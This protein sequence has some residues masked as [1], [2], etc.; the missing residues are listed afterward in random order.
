MQPALK[1]TSQLEHWF[2][3]A[4]QWPDAVL[5]AYNGGSIA[6]L[7]G[8]ILRA[9]DPNGVVAP[10]TVLPPVAPQLLPP[11]F[12]AG[13]RAVV[14]IVVD[15]LGQECLRWASGQ[16]ATHYLN[17]AQHNAQLTS[18][19]PSTTA[20]ALTSLQNGLAPARH[21]MAGYTLYLA[22]QQ[23]VINMITW[24]P[25]AGM[26]VRLPMPVPRTFLDVPNLYTLLDRVKIPSAIVSNLAFMD[27]P[28]TN[29]HSPGVPYYGHRTP[30]EFAGLLLQQV[31]KPGR[32]FVFGYWDGFD[33]LAHTHG[34]R[35]IICLDEIRIVDLALGRGLLER[36]AGRA[37]DIVV[38]L[39]ADHGHMMISEDR[40]HSLK[41]IIRTYSR[42]RPIPTGDRRAAGLTFDDDDALAA[43]RENAGDDGVVVPVAE[44]IEA[45]LYGPAHH[46]ANLEDRIGKALVLAKDDAAFVYPQSSNP[47]AGGHGSLTSSEMLV[48]LLGWRFTS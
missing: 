23:A 46:H 11:D 42:S 25:V 13:A 24:K 40:T 45:G 32:R 21:G 31:E 10:G 19:F 36:L 44:A 37:D 22:A 47:T 5:P 38:L 17:Q 33:A 18:V 2:A 16:T 15:G 26:P 30:A 9:F 14:L 3:S 34:P 8:S 28:L 4:V 43:L 7:P 39:V 41:N 12:L 48:P 1:A 35:S 27:S 29:V 20:A 6:N